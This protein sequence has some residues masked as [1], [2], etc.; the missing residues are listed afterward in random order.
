MGFFS[1]DNDGKVEDIKNEV[2]HINKNLEAIADMIDKGE[3]YCQ[4]NSMEFN[5]SL[6]QIINMYERLQQDLQ[7]IPENRLMRITVAW[8]GSLERHPIVFWNM[9]FLS[10]MNNITAVTSDWRL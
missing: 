7:L 4:Q 8:N 6:A 1:S 2:R 3:I 5:G 10:I 9:S